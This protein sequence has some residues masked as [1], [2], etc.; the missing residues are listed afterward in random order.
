M[1]ISRIER[2]LRKTGM[3]PTKLGRLAVSDPRF[4]LDVRRGR[5][6]RP[7]T[8]RRLDQFMRKYRETQA[9]AD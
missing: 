9:N 2:F 6:P 4:V 1:L 3:P 8:E 7:R 5:L